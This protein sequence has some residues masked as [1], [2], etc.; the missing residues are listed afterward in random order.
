MFPFSD[1]QMKEILR[2]RLCQAAEASATEVNPDVRSGVWLSVAFLFIHK[3][4]NTAT[5]KSLPY[6]GF[7]FVILDSIPAFW[8]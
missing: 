2:E 4:C 5:M 7:G 6:A 8:K 3:S 1:I